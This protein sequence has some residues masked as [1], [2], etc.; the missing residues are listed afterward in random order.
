[1]SSSAAAISDET[2]IHRIGGASVENLYLKPVE[3]RLVPPGI[4]VFHGGSPADAAE[5]MR[6]RF[7]RMAPRG[8]TVVGT[9]TAGRIR[10]AGFDVTMDATARFSQHA[11]LVHPDG[12]G[13]FTQ[14]NLEPLAQSFTNHSGL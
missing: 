8:Q 14:E 11:R 13:G 6:R 7:P 12:A 10:Q 9:T 1:V 4:S 2:P 3:A 5:A